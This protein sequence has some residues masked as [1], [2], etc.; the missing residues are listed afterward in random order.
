M[1]MHPIC[2]TV[3]KAANR[4]FGKDDDLIQQADTT[5]AKPFVGQTCRRSKVSSLL[6]SK[7]VNIYKPGS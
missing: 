1:T 7:G 3:T 4:P 5:N 2:H 6:Q